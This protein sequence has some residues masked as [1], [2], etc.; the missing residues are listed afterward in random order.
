[1]KPGWLHISKDRPCEAC[2]KPDWCTRTDDGAVFC[3]RADE[4]PPGWR[5]VKRGTKGGMILRRKGDKGTGKCAPRHIAAPERGE[6]VPVRNWGALAKHFQR[7]A[8][9][10]LIAELADSLHLSVASLTALN[11]GYDAKRAAYTFPMSIAGKVVGIRTRPI[12]GE[13]PRSIFGSKTGLFVPTTY[14]ADATL[15]VCEGESDTAALLTVGLN[16][17]GRASCLDGEKA[18]RAQGHKAGLVIVGDNDD[19]GRAGAKR[20]GEAFKSPVVFPPAEFKDVRAMLVAGEPVREYLL[21]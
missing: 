12:G 20:L 13:R 8:T 3:M 1:M 18:L 10:A 5:L 15:F 4:I 9:A 6:H 11:V 14:D 7:A 17:V 19:E 16:A 21:K 2:G